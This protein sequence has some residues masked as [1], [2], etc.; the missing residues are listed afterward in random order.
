M[1]SLRS[2]KQIS[3][4]MLLAIFIVAYAVPLDNPA[5][6]T[7]RGTKELSSAFA[8]VN[9]TPPVVLSPV[10]G[11]LEVIPPG[12]CSGTKWCFNQHKT[13]GH[14]VGGGICQADDTYAWDVNLN[15]PTWDEDKG[16][17]V[18]ACSSGVV[19]QTYG[20]CLNTNGGYG[21]VLLEHTYQGSKWWSGYLHM[22]NIAV[23]PGQSVTENTIIGY[24]SNVHV[25]DGNNHLHFVVYTGSNTQGGLVSFNTTITERLSM[26][27]SA[28]W[29]SK[30]LFYCH[31]KKNGDGTVTLGAL[32][33]RDMWYSIKIYVKSGNQL[34]HEMSPQPWD[35]PYLSPY[36]TKDFIYTPKSGELVKISV[37]NDLNDQTLS[38]IYSL[39]FF[40]RALLGFSISSQITNP[41][42][43]LVE[44][45]TFYNDY[46]NFGAYL[47]TGDWKNAL[48]KAAKLVATD[49]GKKA[50]VDL[51]A[52][53]GI[54]TSIETVGLD[55]V[56]MGAAYVMNIPVWW[57]LIQNTNKEPF[58]PDE[59]I[60]TPVAIEAPVT[61][62]TD[63]TERV[64]ISPSG[65]YSVG[66]TIQARFSIINQ[67]T[68]P[69]TLPV[70]TLGGRGPKGN[71]DIRDFTHWTNVTL[72]PNV[73]YQYTGVLKLLTAGDYHFFAAYQTTDGQWNCNVGSDRTRSEKN[74]T[75]QNVP[76]PQTQADARAAADVTPP[77][78][79]ISGFSAGETVP[80]GSSRTIR[81]SASD[82]VNV[83]TTK[84]YY[85][86]DNWE[87]FA[88]IPAQTTGAA[89][90]APS[91]STA[92]NSYSWTVPATNTS[93]A[94]VK[95]IATDSAGN[96]GQSSCSLFIISTTPSFPDLL[97]TNVELSNSIPTAGQQITAYTTVANQGDTQSLATT[98][99]L[100]Y[101]KTSG[102][103]DNYIGQYSVP[104]LTVGATARIESA[105]TL[106][107][108]QMGDVYIV[109]VANPDNTI[110][111]KSTTNNAFSTKVTVQDN[112]VP[113]ITYL[114]LQYGT[115][116]NQN[117]FMTTHEYTVVFT[118]ND[119]VGIASADF[120]YSTDGGNIWSPIVTN[121][122]IGSNAVS[123][124]FWWT[125]PS[126]T[127][128][129]TNGIIKMIARDYAG[130]QT[131]LLSSVFTI[132]DG[133]PPA[134]QLLSP[135]GG[136]IWD[137]GSSHQIKWAASS[138]AGISRIW[139]QLYYG[140]STW[141]ISNVTVNS[142]SYTWTIPNQSTFI[143]SVAKIR[144]SVE[145]VN[146]NVTDD[147]SDGYFTIRDPSQPPP[148]PWTTPVRLTTVPSQSFTSK[149]DTL[150]AVST[151]RD[152]T[153]H[154]VYMY[155]QRQS[156]VPVTLTQNIY[157]SKLTGS[158]WSSPELVYSLS[159]PDTGTDGFI[160]IGGLQ[161][162][163]DS[164][165][166][167]YIVWTQGPNRTVTDMNQQE[168]YYA[169]R[170]AGS[171][172]TPVNLSANSTA[173]GAPMITVDSSSKV[174][175]VWIDGATMNADF[176]QTGVNNIYYKRKDLATGNWSSAALLT[177]EGTQH[178]TIASDSSGNV[179][180]IFMIPHKIY[181][182]K[183]SAGNW[184]TPSL[185]IDLDLASS[186]DARWPMLA[187]GNG[188][189]LHLVWYETS[190]TVQK[191]MYS[192][193]NGSTWTAPEEVTDRST[194]VM[195]PSYPSLAVDSSNY[196]HVSWED[197]NHGAVMYMRK[198]P[199]GWTN[200][201]KLNLDSQYIEQGSSKIAIS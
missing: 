80:A 156:T 132:I 52:K 139:L 40:V 51:L 162:A 68:A 172:S 154:L 144:V 193:Y 91:A 125:I 189:S 104:G 70:L 190:T 67:G 35:L 165:G 13:G 105:F 95:I 6:G 123:S 34:W 43:F 50:L 55:C 149:D 17:P 4:L 102:G 126:N 36:G 65:P 76:A 30:Q 167:P 135:N 73:P 177:T 183:W 16:K 33:R 8:P 178:Q 31:Y 171:W 11:P 174:H 88:E 166:N 57:D 134:V 92:I 116:S 130:N 195:Y 146:H 75:V 71:N 63:L 113:A 103:R 19:A 38:A 176:S 29:D 60:W 24:I 86:T 141:S 114:K 7:T 21:Q 185:A 5:E 25:P 142:G 39:D 82:D 45:L 168:I 28:G 131:L 136:E 124:G 180:L 41:S 121:Y 48:L 54:T 133:T 153:V 53:D 83:L 37:R 58:E 84:L 143:T 170:V 78:V 150:Q 188:N 85:T 198:N 187:A 93:S 20:S 200:H 22:T 127:P 194:D 186:Y 192:S 111:E 72:S 47:G 184:T 87:T 90:P 97:V 32:N 159:G 96:V 145:D 147:Y 118:A 62:G 163:G 23:S 155:T 179:H 137:L 164:S 128:L 152:G 148:A 191:I 101:S 109:A 10:T 108:T 77:T 157:Y 106:P 27:P 173:S 64:T 158:N 129:T 46:L 197:T 138:S 9:L 94:S 99:K 98:M 69:V 140:G 160:A 14:V 122:I 115:G 79:S 119:N 61:A 59:V 161:I 42:E 81:W 15:Y 18:Y 1:K 201:I 66:Q 117:I 2:T 89:K 12:T 175:V 110:A 107:S 199:T 44:C 169:S 182:M 74:I 112:Q 151:G 3:R 196:P 100:Y 120:F 181:Y 26:Q 56:F 49:A